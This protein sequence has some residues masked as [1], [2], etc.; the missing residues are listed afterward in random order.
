M[1]KEMVKQVFIVLYILAVLL[2][3]G[4]SRAE[5]TEHAPSVLHSSG[6]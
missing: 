6:E 2:I 3:A 5:N 4:F 1:K